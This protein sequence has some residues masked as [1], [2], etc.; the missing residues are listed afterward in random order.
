MPDIQRPLGKTAA[1][2]GAVQLAMSSVVK[3]DKLPTP[4]AVFGHQAIVPAWGDLGNS[5][6]GDCVWAGA[7][8]EHMLWT[9]AGGLAAPASFTDVDVLSDYS[10]VTGF[11]FS[12]DTDNGTDMQQAASYRRK[13]GVRDVTGK[14]HQITAYMALRVGDFDEMILAAYLFGAVGIGVNFPKSASD[15]FD[16]RQPWTVVPNSTVMGGHYVPIVGRAPNGNAIAV[17][18]GRA[19]EITP[20]FYKTYN[21]ESIAYFCPEYVNAL[22]LSP[23]GFNIAALSRM[24]KELTQA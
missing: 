18:W 22:R 19:Q 16:A 9:R 11:E 10:I 2:P 1:R 20:E 24:L 23:E 6:W 5:D 14:R 8:H 3:K 15:Q 21:D 17:T 13:T 4:P 12:D 7:A